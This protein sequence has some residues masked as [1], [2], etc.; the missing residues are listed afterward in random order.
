M[1]SAVVF[2]CLISVIS[3]FPT[4]HLIARRDTTSSEECMNKCSREVKIVCG[5]DGMVYPNNC[6]FDCTRAFL[7]KDLESVEC[8]FVSFKEFKAHNDLGRSSD[9]DDS[10]Q[11]S[12]ASKESKAS[13]V[14]PNSNDQEDTQALLTLARLIRKV[15]D[16]EEE[17]NDDDLE[18]L[19]MFGDASSLTYQ[20]GHGKER[21]TDEIQRTS[22]KSVENIH[23]N[24]WNTLY[25]LRK[26]NQKLQSAKHAKRYVLHE[27]DNIV[28]NLK[29]DENRSYDPNSNVMNKVEYLLKEKDQS[30]FPFKRHLIDHGGLTDNVLP[31]YKLED[32]I[33]EPTTELNKQGKSVNVEI[34]HSTDMSMESNINNEEIGRNNEGHTVE[35]IAATT[36]DPD[37]FIETERSHD[38]GFKVDTEYTDAPDVFPNTETLENS[39]KRIITYDFGSTSN[40]NDD[41]LTIPF[42]SQIETTED[43]IKT[44]EDIEQEMDLQSYK[45][46]VDREIDEITAII[47]AME[48][49]TTTE[50]VTNDSME[51]T[52]VNDEM[53]DQTN[54]SEFIEEVSKTD[55]PENVS[56]YSE[57]ISE[58]DHIPVLESSDSISKFEI[59]DTDDNGKES[60]ESTTQLTD[61]KVKTK[62]RNR[63]SDS[64][65]LF[66]SNSL[67][68]QPE[69]NTTQKFQ[70][71][72]DDSDSKNGI[73]EFNEFVDSNTAENAQKDSTSASETDITALPISTSTDE[74]S[75]EKNEDIITTESTEGSSGGITSSSIFRND[76]SLA[77]TS[78][79]STVTSSTDVTSSSSSSV[80]SRN[81]YLTSTLSAII[82]NGAASPEVTTTD[83]DTIYDATSTDDTI[84]GAASSSDPFVGAASVTGE[85][86]LITSEEPIL[87]GNEPI[88]IPHPVPE[89]SDD[90]DRLVYP[91]TSES[92]ENLFVGDESMN[93]PNYLDFVDRPRPHL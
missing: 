54:T 3:S 36:S 46:N 37:D 64:N 89:D 70:E 35:I 31:L 71:T 92:I 65:E 68:W 91:D 82:D 27:L 26:A 39:N 77:I 47:D 14:F 10:Q 43:Y 76:P 50:L 1:I 25:A 73:T 28:L 30:S 51:T 49:A 62:S 29:D 13:Q 22:V 78:D 87:M 2:S 69:D 38:E 83:V 5:N 57:I 44:S 86:E 81:T 6:L 19:R 63:I 42:L 74:S 45:E 67:V 11:S 9:Q 93:L 55:V 34:E 20:L 66:T 72:A 24:I 61:E 53:T 8:P 59:L 52:T 15:E 56:E 12:S 21:I 80:D 18:T 58:T 33:P 48:E 41:H 88:F 84:V 4:D 60:E 40:G 16:K 17:E 32:K 23:Q 7:I 79:T 90:F 75:R 85:K